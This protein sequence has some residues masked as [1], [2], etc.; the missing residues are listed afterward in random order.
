M[1]YRPGGPGRGT[2]TAPGRLR[3]RPSLSRCPRHQSPRAGSV[4]LLQHNTNLFSHRSRLYSGASLKAMLPSS[5]VL[6]WASITSM[7]TPIF[8]VSYNIGV[9][10]KITQSQ[11]MQLVEQNLK[12]FLFIFVWINTERRLSLVFFEGYKIEFCKLWK[13]KDCRAFGVLCC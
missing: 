6:G 2:W 5:A 9:V 1:F 8:S 7:V 13:T 3:C 4:L 10:R 12:M 11:I